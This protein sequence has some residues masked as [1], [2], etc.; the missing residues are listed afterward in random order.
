LKNLAILVPAKN[1]AKVIGAT[2]SAVLAA[3]VSPEDVY[4]I[5]DGSS[6]LTAEIARSFGINVKENL[7]PRGKAEAI[8][9]GA[10][11]FRLTELYDG[12]ALLD[13]HDNALALLNEH[14]TGRV[15]KDLDDA[16]RN[17]LQAYVTL[18]DN[19]K[20]LESELG[21]DFGNFE[22]FYGQSGTV[23]SIS[24]GQKMQFAEGV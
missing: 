10:H 23:R 5:S 7:H 3:G 17:L 2:L 8:R 14:L 12:I 4:L 21:S 22:R 9:S 24:R 15:Y 11:H 1:E 19:A 6:D 16:L 20:E 13:A 18:R